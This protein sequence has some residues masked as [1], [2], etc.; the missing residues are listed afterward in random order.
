M[1]ILNKF[2]VE[3]GQ[4]VINYCFKLIS[5]PKIKNGLTWTD[6]GGC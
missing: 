4:G 2:M 5:V 1:E 6:G 3:I